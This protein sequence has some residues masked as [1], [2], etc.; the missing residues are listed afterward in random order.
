[1]KLW[2][3]KPGPNSLGV[4]EKVVMWR[5]QASTEE[6]WVRGKEEEGSG[7]KKTLG[8]S[9]GLVGLTQ[10]VDRLSDGAGKRE[11]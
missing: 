9:S 4:T 5:Q 10:Q 3:Q 7:Q 2:G 1:M 11:W 8:P 6:V